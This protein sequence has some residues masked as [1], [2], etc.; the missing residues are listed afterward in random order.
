MQTPDNT[1]PDLTINEQPDGSLVIHLITDKARE[2]F[3]DMVSLDSNRQAF[4][5]GFH[6]TGERLAISGQW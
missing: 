1:K 3:L 5:F 6:Y 4:R 2:A